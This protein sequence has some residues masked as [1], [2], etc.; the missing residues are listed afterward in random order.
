MHQA[1]KVSVSGVRGVVG[2]SFTPQVATAFSQAFGTFVGEGRVIV[3]RDTRPS[4]LMIQHAVVAG[5]QSVGCRPVLAGVVPTPTLLYLVQ[6]VGARGGIVITASHNPFEWNA[7]KFAD[8]NGLFLSSVRAEELF[9][10]YHQQDASAVPEQDLRSVRRLVDPMQPH[11]DAIFNYVDVDAIRQARFKVAVDCCNGVGAAHTVSFLQEGLGCEV[12]SIFDEPHGQFEREPEPLPENLGTLSQAVKA[13]GCTIGFAQD[14]DGDRLAVVDNHG[15]PIGENMTLALAVRQVLKA[16]EQGPVVINQAASKTVEWV[17][18]QFGSEVVRSKTGE[19]N[20]SET[21][22]DI[23]AVVGGE[24]TGGVIIPGIHPCRDSYAAMA[25]ILE[26]LAQERKT[27][28]DIRNDMPC[29]ALVKD[30]VEVGGGQAPAIL[31]SIRTRY[32]KYPI[33]TMDGVFV[34][35]GESWLQVRRSNTEPVVRVIVEA[36]T[37]AK[38]RAIAAEARKLIH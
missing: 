32:A 24:H 37:E 26:G 25:V 11:V 30:K 31:R 4:G 15:M 12:V 36:P 22:R 19:V 34:D 8:R 21:M 7:L 10:I 6:H 20:V 1:L 35:M 13:H 27:V 16:H 38:A 14:P 3:G 17:A 2:T 9:D 29:Y 33:S 18:R 5:L 28:S 23:E